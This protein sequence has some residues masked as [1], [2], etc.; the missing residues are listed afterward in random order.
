MT[1]APAPLSVLPTVLEGRR[2][3]DG[4]VDALRALVDDALPPSEAGAARGDA[5]QTGA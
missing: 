4:A 2:E 1:D 5:G 3:L